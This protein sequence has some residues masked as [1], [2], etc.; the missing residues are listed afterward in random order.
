MTL[1]AHV[2]HWFDRAWMTRA[3]WQ[4]RSADLPIRAMKMSRL[5]RLHHEHGWPRRAAPLVLAAMAVLS[6]IAAQQPQIRVLVVTGGHD[7][8]TGF[9][10]LF[11]GYPDVR[12]DHR[13]HRAPADGYIRDLAKRYDVV[14]LYDMEQDAP[15]TQRRNLMDFVRAGGGVVALHHALASLPQW[16]EFHDLIGGAYLQRAEAGRPASTYQ[17]DVRMRI[18]VADRA[19]PVTRGIE[20]FEVEDEVY[21]GLWVSPDARVLL[22]TDHPASSKAVAWAMTNAN[23]RVVAIQPG[24]GEPAFADA[25]YRRLVIQAIRW[26]ARRDR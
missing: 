24:H 19:H 16:K 14:V 22:T 18:H 26:A 10:T 20:D 6:P 17:H 9:Y 21:G 8:P 2:Y 4:R 1:F 23:A 13:A 7:Y 3:A 11:Q 15:E 12:W 5:L 25:S